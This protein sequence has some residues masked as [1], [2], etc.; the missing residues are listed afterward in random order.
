MSISS[1]CVFWL[2]L[3]GAV[4][5]TAALAE[6]APARRAVVPA[7]AAP[8]AMSSLFTDL[9]AGEQTIAVPGAAWLQLQLADVALGEGSLTITGADG[10]SQTFSQQQIDDWQGLTAVFNGDKLSIKLSPGSGEALASARVADIIIGLPGGPASREAALP[11]P[12]SDLLGDNLQRFIPDDAAPLGTEGVQPAIGPAVESIC[13]TTDDRIA[14]ANPR[15]GRIM[16]IGCTGWLIDGGAFLTA[17]HC[18]TPA[19]QT[20]EFNVPASLANGTTVAPPVRDQ[21]RIAAGSMVSQNG[22]QGNDWAVFRVVPNTETGLM[23]AGVQGAT[24]QLS[25][26]QNPAQVRVTGYGVDGPGPGFGAGGPRDATN[27]TQQTHSGAL[28]GNTGGPSNGTLTYVPDTQG[29]NSGSPV[30][31]EGTN[32]AIGIHTNGGCGP[33]G[34]A[35]AGT[36]FRNAS[37][38]AAVQTVQRRTGDVLWQHINGQV[39]Y[40]PML[41]GQ[42]QGGINI[43]GPVGP[44]WRL[45]GGGDVN[46]DGTEDVLWQHINGQVH[47]WPTLNGVRQGGL[48]IAGPV[49]PEWR[50]IGAG[51]LNGDGTDDILWQHI[52]GQVHFWPMQNGE[53]QGGID[54]AGPV[55]PEWKLIGSGDFNGDGTDDILWQH[56]NGQVH[57][58]P[59]LNGV[60]QGG[61]NIAGPVG[62]EWRLAGAGDLNADGTDDILWQHINGQVHWW[63]ILSGVRQGGIDI[64]GPVGPEWRLRGVASVD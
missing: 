60:R 14:S 46:G 44:E 33:A 3:S 15:A 35:N 32:V 45:I 43:A 25:N 5:A 48:N 9:A 34:G 64:A 39:H 56:I 11:D 24:F 2:A 50:M 41:S 49:G 47:W 13:G 19:A 12:L 57:W 62:P 31:V 20:V 38:W 21:Y 16:P 52:N 42:R 10:Q 7:D 55:G 23:P 63:P 58:W 26:T 6:T 54:I 4:F 61:L 18:A 28:N 36:S 22:G 8:E 1:R 27:Q 29:G 40:W 37:L 51:D 53:R 30:I 17:G 59:M